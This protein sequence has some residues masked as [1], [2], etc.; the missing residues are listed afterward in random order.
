MIT[1]IDT[2]SLLK[3]L[4]DEEG[5]ARVAWIWDVS[6]VVVSVALVSI[7]ARAAL[8]AAHRGRRLTDQAHRRAK[9]GLALVADSLTLVSVTDALVDRAGDLAEQQGL[10]G[11]DAVHLASAELVGA[12]VLASADADLCV[13]AGRLGMHAANPL[14]G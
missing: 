12:R 7:E 11:Y 1:Y 3:L 10:R 5:S 9:A 8:A 2:S 4:I 6:D 14:D 13:A